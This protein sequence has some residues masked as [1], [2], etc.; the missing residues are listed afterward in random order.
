MSANVNSL[1]K[2]SFPL[3]KKF[4]VSE[5][6]LCFKNIKIIYLDISKVDFLEKKKDRADGLGFSVISVNLC[7][8]TSHHLIFSK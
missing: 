3:F 6:K 7:S 2:M 5:P 4:H 1:Y 8:M